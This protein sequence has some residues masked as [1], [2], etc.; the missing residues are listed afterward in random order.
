MER[1]ERLVEV[2]GLQIVRS[3]YRGRSATVRR[4]ETMMEHGR[5]HSGVHCSEHACTDLLRV[6]HRCKQETHQQNDEIA[7][8]NFLSCA[9]K[10]LCVGTQ[11]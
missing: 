1:K 11:V 5:L 7:N 4:Y 2:N 9:R 6:V 10:R 8:V 3:A